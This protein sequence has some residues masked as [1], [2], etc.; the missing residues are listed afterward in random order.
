MNRTFNDG[1]GMCVIISS[2][3]AAALKA[4]LESLGE[5]VYDIGEITTL[6]GG[7]ASTQGST[8]VTLE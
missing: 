7:S 6:S 3:H 2:E 5:T 4:E 8:R 1:I